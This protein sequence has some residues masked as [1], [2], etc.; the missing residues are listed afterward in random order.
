LGGYVPGQEA[1]ATLELFQLDHYPDG[2][3]LWRIQWHLGPI[4]LRDK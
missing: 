2:K 3:D 4:K 1:T